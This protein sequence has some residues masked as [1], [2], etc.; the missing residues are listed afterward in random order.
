MNL[1][2]LVCLQVYKAVLVFKF[3][4]IITRCV[5]VVLL[6]NFEFTKLSAVCLFKSF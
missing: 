3:L 2:I 4:V 1:D 5:G 6:K